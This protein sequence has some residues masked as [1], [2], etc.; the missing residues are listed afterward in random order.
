MVSE[1]PGT[2]LAGIQYTRPLSDTCC[3]PDNAT[4]PFLPGAH[5]TNTAG[6]GLVHT[7]PAHGQDDFRIGEWS[8]HSPL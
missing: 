6:T 8:S 1:V 4:C 5:V 7:A 3:D 2:E